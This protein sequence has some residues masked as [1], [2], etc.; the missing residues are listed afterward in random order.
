MGHNE[1]M[2]SALGGGGGGGG[3][4]VGCFSHLISDGGESS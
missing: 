1:D 2:V 4:G 3:G